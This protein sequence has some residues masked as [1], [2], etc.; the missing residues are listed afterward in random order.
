MS[1]KR[2]AVRPRHTN[3]GQED[4]EGRGKPEKQRGAFPGDASKELSM[5]AKKKDEEDRG[6]HPEHRMQQGIGDVQKRGVAKRGE[7]GAVRDERQ[8]HNKQP[9]IP[10][11]ILRD[12]NSHA[13]S[14]VAKNALAPLEEVLR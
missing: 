5:A 1:V 3:D 2:Q 11:R 10:A 14:L 7:I 9:L 4:S 6:D 8:R 12:L 13:I